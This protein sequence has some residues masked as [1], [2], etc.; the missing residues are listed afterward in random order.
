[1]L[2]RFRA[3]LKCDLLIFIVL[4]FY[5]FNPIQRISSFVNSESEAQSHNFFR[6]F[7]AYRIG[8]SLLLIKPVLQ[9]RVIQKDRQPSLATLELIFER[10][11][12]R[13]S[14]KDLPLCRLSSGRR[15]KRSWRRSERRP[16]LPGFLSGTTRS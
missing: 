11:D 2:Q 8:R 4:S 13:K 12:R 9:A 1:M 7:D 10:S 6:L 5:Y 3:L 16:A 14:R 15:H